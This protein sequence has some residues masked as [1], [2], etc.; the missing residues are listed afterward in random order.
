MKPQPRA[1][2]GGSREHNHHCCR[3]VPHRLRHR[4]QGWRNALLRTAA[5]REGGRMT[6]QTPRFWAHVVKSD[7]C[8]LWNGSL[9]R[10]GYGT[11]SHSVK[12]KLAH[13]YSWVL[14]NGPI[15][16][17]LFVCHHCD[18]RNCVRPDHLF[19]GTHS[20][21]M[22]DALAKGRYAHQR[23][24]HCKNGHPRSDY[25]RPLRSP[26]KP[27]YCIQCS[28]DEWHRRADRFL[29]AGLNVSGRPYK[30]PPGWSTCL[31]GHAWTPENTRITTV[32][33][34]MCRACNSAKERERYAR[35]S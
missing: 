33:R 32:G 11:L 4:L 21:N 23:M 30:T 8:W 2:H 7:G 1:R 17:G 6:D 24:T 29:A 26:D 13:R 12:P 18:V 16:V 9:I 15:P 20:D 5:K 35:S 3:G 10:A 28:R 14:H 31:R 25:A 27:R 34:R 22:R 19:L